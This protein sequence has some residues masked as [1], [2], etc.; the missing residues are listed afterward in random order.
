MTY[1]YNAI[2][3]TPEGY[4]R[5]GRKG[6]KVAALSIDATQDD[7][8]RKTLYGYNGAG[9]LERKAAYERLKARGLEA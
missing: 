5:Q 1:G 4:I 8:D 6:G 9:P 7:Q 3:H 2:T